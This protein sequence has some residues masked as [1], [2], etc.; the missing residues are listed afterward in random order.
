MLKFLC[1]PLYAYG[2]K[3]CC[4]VSISRKK[5]VNF[6]T[7]V[8]SNL[9]EIWICCL[10]Q[11]Y[12]WHLSTTNRKSH[13]FMLKITKMERKWPIF[14]PVHYDFTFISLKRLGVCTW[15]ITNSK[16]LANNIR[17]NFLDHTKFHTI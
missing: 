17:N 5:F 1:S 13:I 8:S 9:F 4:H 7:S 11:I 16:V 15:Q 6:F 12:S 10:E 3:T 2:R 14:A